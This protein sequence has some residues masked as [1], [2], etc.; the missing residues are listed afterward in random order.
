MGLFDR[1]GGQ[2]ARAFGR[3]SGPTR[4]PNVVE[5]PGVPRLAGAGTPVNGSPQVDRAARTLEALLGLLSLAGAAGIR[6]FRL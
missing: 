2:L 4:T 1:L 5:V 3:R 6:S